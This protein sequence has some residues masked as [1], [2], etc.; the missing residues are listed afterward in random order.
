MT[1]GTSDHWIGTAH[2]QLFARAW[3]PADRRSRSDATILLFHDSLGCA[4]LRR[5]FPPGLAAATR[6]TVVAYDGLDA[7]IPLGHSVGGGMAVATGA[8][9]VEDCAALVNEAAQS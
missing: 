1:V 3:V 5:D 9:L 4:E 6:R 8:H 2:G 7:L